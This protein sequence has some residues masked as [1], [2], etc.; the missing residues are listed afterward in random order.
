V[1]IRVNPK[2]IG[3]LEK[4]GAQDVQKCY[5]CGNCAATCPFSKEPHTIPRRSMRYLQMGLEER[6]KSTV[7][8]W[9]CY[10]CG[11][12][13]DQ[14]PRD[15]QPG[16]TMMSLRR[17][18]VGQYDITR[19]ARLF[20]KS[21]KL[22]VVA[23]VLVALLAGIGFFAFGWRYGDIDVYDGPNA[24]LPPAS[25]HLFD[26]IL[27]LC[28]ASLLLI[29]AVHMWWYILGRSQRSYPIVSYIKAFYLLPLHFFTQKR[30]VE[31]EKKTPWAI[32]ILVMLS[33]VTM[34]ILIVFFLHRMQAGPEIWWAVHVFGY[35]AAI[36][37][38]G[39]AAYAI[40]GRLLAVENHYKN[41]HATDWV[42]L[43]LIL[44]VAGTGVA[45]H[46]LHRLGSAPAA[47][48]AYVVHMMGVL[49]LIVVQIPFGKLSHM[50]YRPLGMYFA[51]IQRD[52]FVREAS[53]AARGE[54]PKVT[55]GAE[56]VKRVA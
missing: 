44:F 1:A 24:F 16:E 7:E 46:L 10:Y 8:P 17:W 4:Y 21:A 55:T 40:R 47:N 13:T 14:C 42:F 18:L 45:Q 31:C 43:I 53:A 48:I 5:H 3:E 39:G 15:A 11:E 6:L 56:S 51:E 49:P 27:W 52:V 26:V 50:I 12:C 32:H 35:A 25:V 41:S 29:N 22:E 20:Y 36:G 38:V 9:L 37:L 30:Y 2:L 23:V 34:E 28:L 54:S 19:I 33:W